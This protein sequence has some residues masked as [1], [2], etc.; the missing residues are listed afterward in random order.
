MAALR[1]CVAILLTLVAGC[2]SESDPQIWIDPP[3]SDSQLCR[4]LCCKEKSAACDGRTGVC[5][6]CNARCEGACTSARLLLQCLDETARIRLVCAS[7]GSVVPETDACDDQLAS[8]QA[9]TRAC[10]RPEAAL[11]GR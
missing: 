7:D 1:R 8:Y 5:E 10:G 11:G 2:A 4:S 9:A 3:E 6:E